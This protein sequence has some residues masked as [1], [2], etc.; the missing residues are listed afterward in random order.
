MASPIQE[1]LQ[2]LKARA[3]APEGAPRPR[4]PRPRP[5][6][7]LSACATRFHKMSQSDTPCI[8]SSGEVPTSPSLRHHKLDPPLVRR[9]GPGPEPTR[10]PGRPAPATRPSSRLLQTGTWCARAWAARS[11]LGG[12]VRI[13]QAKRCDSASPRVPGEGREPSRG[14]DGGGGAHTPSP[15]DFLL[16]CVTAR[17]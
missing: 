12:G 2:P 16:I 6:G 13:A 4:T 9:A 3:R 15:A 8:L 10:P 14:L 5:W 1:G 11:A 7:A 17:E